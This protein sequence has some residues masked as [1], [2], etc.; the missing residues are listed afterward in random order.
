M[1]DNTIPCWIFKSARK[2]EMYLYLAQEDGYD[3][4]PEMLRQHFG[5]ALFVMQLDL[6]PGRPLARADVAIVMNALEEQG[7]YLQMPPKLEPEM[8]YGE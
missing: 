3:D 5:K 4:L 6:Q 2:Q 7:Y 1:P 8:N